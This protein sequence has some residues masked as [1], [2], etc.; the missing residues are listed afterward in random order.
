M[1]WRIGPYSVRQGSSIRIA[2]WWDE[3]PGVQAIQALPFDDG[4]I[5]GGG[6]RI[7]STSA[8]TITEQ[9]VEN[10]P[11]RGRMGPYNTRLTYFV[12]VA[13]PRPFNNSS[14]A[15]ADPVTFYIRG[16]KVG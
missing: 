12:T 13:A 1:A 8:V 15:R 10:E 7:L 4:S 5:S 6:I 3:D 16:G 9:R 11:G 14:I 2:F